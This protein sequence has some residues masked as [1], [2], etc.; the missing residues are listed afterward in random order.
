MLCFISLF[1]CYLLYRPNGLVPP[2]CRKNEAS[3]DQKQTKNRPSIHPKSS[4]YLPKSRSKI[5]TSAPEP[6]SSATNGPKIDPKSTQDRFQSR[7]R[8]RD[9]FWI[10]FDPILEPTWGHFG[11]QNRSMLA[12]KSIFEG[13]RRQSKTTMIFNTLRDPLGSDFVPILWSEIDPKLIQNRSQERSR[14]KAAHLR[15]HWEFSMKLRMRVIEDRSKINQN[16]I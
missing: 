8:F 3:I 12:E 13:S 9:R 11:G 16:R 6:I 1:V 14:E 10:D 7:F 15:F 4:Q 2:T 5:K